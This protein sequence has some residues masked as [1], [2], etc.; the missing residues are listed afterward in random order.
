MTQVAH[1]R[2]GEDSLASYSAPVY[3]V[4]IGNLAHIKYKGEKRSF[5]EFLDKTSNGFLS[6][7]AYLS[8]PFEFPNISLIGDCG[9][10]SY[11]NEPQP[12][13]KRNFVTPE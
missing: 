5:W 13:L 12:K 2:L 8:G 1:C 7:L 9:A 3:N 11:K 10:W 6:S 4:V